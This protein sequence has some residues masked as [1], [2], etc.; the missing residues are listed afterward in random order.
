MNNVVEP[1]SDCDNKFTTTSAAYNS[2]NT[3][4][5]ENTTENNIDPYVHKRLIIL[6]DGIDLYVNKTDR[7]KFLYDTKKQNINITHQ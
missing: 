1:F 6:D 5:P 4:Q 3:T 7:T 2:S